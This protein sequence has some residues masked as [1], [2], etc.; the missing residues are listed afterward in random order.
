[1]SDKFYELG[2]MLYQ[3]NL[4]IVELAF[5]VKD[6]KA[7]LKELYDKSPFD[8]NLEELYQ[9]VEKALAK[10]DKIDLSDNDINTTK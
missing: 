9:R 7:L 2:R 10:L 3:K 4:T 8:A 1:M 6:L 5:D